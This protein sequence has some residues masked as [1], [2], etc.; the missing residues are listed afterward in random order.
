MSHVN[1]Y[2]IWGNYRETALLVAELREKDDGIITVV[3]EAI[4][5]MRKKHDIVYATPDFV[6]AS[7]SYRHKQVN[8]HYI[9][10]DQRIDGNVWR[11]ENEKRFPFLGI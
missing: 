10:L 9:P 11:I 2:V 5:G 3:D 8:F 1:H 6:E 7:Q 4:N